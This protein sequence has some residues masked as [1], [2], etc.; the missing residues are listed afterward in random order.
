MKHKVRYIFI[1]TAISAAS[2]PA[3]ETLSI[4]KFREPG[5][6]LDVSIQQEV[7]HAMY[8]GTTW[9][10]SRQSENGS[11]QESNTVI[12]TSI[13]ILSLAANN[14]TEIINKALTWLTNNQ[15]AI[16][17]T[18]TAVIAWR[19][20]A[21]SVADSK[22][23]LA[24]RQKSD[25]IFLKARTAQIDDFNTDLCK[26]ILLSTLPAGSSSTLK[27][28]TVDETNLLHPK[29]SL[30]EMWLNARSINNAGGQL[31][32]KKG[33]RIDWRNM[34]AEKIIGTQKID[35]NNGGFW[36]G[37]TSSESIYK[38]ALSILILREL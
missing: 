28:K 3:Q 13:A 5:D 15:P 34:Y 26:E 17:E 9:L 31:L 32:S 23:N 2:I 20:A 38:T 8:L 30:L 25:R 18:E 10:K 37:T 12:N 27:R 35:P 1:I 21:I 24:E 16:N 6:L 19:Y 7:D 36:K 11:F 4:N 22:G 29:I 14:N 33:T